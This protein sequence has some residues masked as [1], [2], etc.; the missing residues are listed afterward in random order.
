MG[1]RQIVVVEAPIAIGK[2]DAVLAA[3]R[4][5]LKPGGKFIV[6]GPNAK[7]GIAIRMLHHNRKAEMG[8]PFGHP[9][10]RQARKLSARCSQSAQEAEAEIGIVK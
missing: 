6:M 5:V 3:V 8:D 10:A 7:Y 1:E 9:R 4:E 2:R